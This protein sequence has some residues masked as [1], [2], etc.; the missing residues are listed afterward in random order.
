MKRFLALLLAAL[1]LLSGCGPATGDESTTPA[2]DGSDVTDTPDTVDSS[3]VTD[4]PDTADPSDVTDAPVT[5]P[6]ETEPPTPVERFDH[7]IAVKE[8]TYVMNKT[9]STDLK[10]TN[11]GSEAEIHIKSNGTSLTRYGYLKFDISSLKGDNDFTSI[12]LDLTLTVRQ[13]EAAAPYAVIEVYGVDT[14][15]TESGITFNKQPELFNLITVK[16]DITSA[17]V[18]NSFPI[19]DYVRKALANGQ[20]EIA[21]YL[22]EATPAVALH[23]R[24][25][26]KE[27]G[28][29][30][31]KLSV[32]Y[33]TKTDNAVYEGLT[34]APEATVSNTGIDS[35]L[36]WG[37]IETQSIPVLEDTY[38]EGGASTNKN[39]G[40][41]E[42]LEHKAPAQNSNT[43]YRVVLLKFDI[44][45]IKSED[46]SNA[47][48][49]LNC[50]SMEKVNTKRVINVYACDSY[51]WEE[52]TVTLETLCEKEE[53]ITQYFTSGVGEKLIDV[54]DY[55]KAAVRAGDDVIAFYLDGETSTMY[56]TTFDSSDKVGG[57]APSLNINYGNT[58]FTTKL[59]YKGENPWDVAMTAVKT[60]LERSKD[61]AAHGRTDAELIVKDPEE[62]SLT[63]D[64]ATRAQTDGANTVYTPY[65]TRNL[66]T[67]KGFKGNAKE[68][69]LYDEY[70]GYMGGEKYEATGYFYTKKIG[71][72]WWNI[73]P[74]G[75][76]FYR[77][78][79][80]QVSHGSSPSQKAVT[81]AKYGTKDA[82]AESAT[83]R[84]REL[85]FNAA[86]GWSE[87]E[88]LYKVDQPIAQTMIFNVATQYGK[89]I[90]VKVSSGGSRLPEADVIPAFDPD[91]AEF[92]DS[93]IKGKVAPYVN[94]P[95]VYGWM[96]DN[97]LADNI[98]MLD[99]ALALDYT[100]VRRMYTYATAWTFMYLKTGKANVSTA[101]VTDELR[102]E[103]IAMTYDKYFEVV[104]SALEKYDPN[105]LYMG[106][107][108]VNNNYKRESVMRV[109]GYWCDVVTFNYYSAWEGDPILMRNIQNWLGETPFVVTE[110]YAKGMDV[111]QQNPL[112]I[113]KTGAGWTVRTQED[114]GKFY[115]N[116]A[117]MLMECK[118]CVGFDWFKY[119]DN[120]PTDENAD[121][122]N[123][124]SNKGM[125]SN[126]GTEY[127]DL[128]DYMK[129]LNRQK[130]TLIEFFD[131]R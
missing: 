96:S 45:E 54:T 100:D 42:V 111:W 82:W 86:G 74:L 16:N 120:D 90:G 92:A 46:F 9:G 127:T 21:L 25:A 88:T 84:L 131:A 48:I 30:A 17:A 39:F 32:Y 38:V 43:T 37:E 18:I 41:A 95:S 7:T 52:N 122:S 24:W 4:A 93:Y 67:L 5:N 87:I 66:D 57:K 69:Q 99:H 34:K 118:G 50:I 77:T 81:L 80:V 26:T 78:A 31:P 108:F 128:S 53:L 102:N 75:Y 105:H 63:V 40:S 79:V 123:R 61:I 116:F 109:A 20:T 6:P 8:D 14:K 12:E 72:R 124:D 107:R 27:S 35:I 47:S 13:Q 62:Y 1:M 22:K 130:Y 110:W 94:D 126:E 121:D 114:R 106:C 59:D 19:T 51:S 104:T 3:D 83:E 98:T 64:V 29:N 56:R 129:E 71:D 10:D 101:D 73:D 65:A 11:F 117:L 36:G 2:T 44:S 85:G 91:F 23:T 112:I 115:Q 60:W 49:L 28:A 76:P 70:G 68:T 58:T 119:W 113:N 55:V 33:G 103:Y 97:E 15:W 125:Y 89:S